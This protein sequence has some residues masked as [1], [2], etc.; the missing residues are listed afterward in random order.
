MQ[1]ISVTQRFMSECERQTELK[2]KISEKNMKP[3]KRAKNSHS[4]AFK[5]LI[6]L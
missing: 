3:D 5:T 6:L 1:N 4:R 2:Q